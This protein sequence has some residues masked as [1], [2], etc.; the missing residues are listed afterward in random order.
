MLEKSCPHTR[1]LQGEDCPSLFNNP[2]TLLT[3]ELR[4][5]GWGPC[6]S[7][8]N[9]LQCPQQIQVNCKEWVGISLKE[10]LETLAN[11]TFPVIQYSPGTVYSLANKN[12]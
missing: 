11:L 10:I 8:F 1:Y 2:S 9:L 5:H 3:L 6:S 4:L 12:N 7:H